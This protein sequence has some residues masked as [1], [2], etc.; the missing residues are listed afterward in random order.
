MKWV[1]SGTATE[2]ITVD[3]TL[4]QHCKLVGTGT[5]Y[6]TLLTS[7]IKAAGNIL[8]RKTNTPLRW[9][10]VT[11]YITTYRDCLIKL[12]ANIDEI[13]TYEYLQNDEWV[14]QTFTDIARSDYQLYTELKSSEIKDCTDYKITCTATLNVDEMLKNACRILVSTMFENNENQHLKATGGVSNYDTILDAF[15][16]GYVAHNL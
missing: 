7:Y 10:N 8:E 16:A 13:T 9:P 11:V 3:D 5:T 12:P 6:D 4:K 14:E 1:G 2:I 15:L